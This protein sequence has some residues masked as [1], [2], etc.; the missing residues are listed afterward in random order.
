MKKLENLLRANIVLTQKEAQRLRR[1]GISKASTGVIGALSFLGSSTGQSFHQLKISFLLRFHRGAY[2]DLGPTEVQ[3]AIEREFSGKYVPFHGSEFSHS[4]Q[5]FYVEAIINDAPIRN[6]EGFLR[7]KARGFAK[8]LVVTH[9]LKIC[10][11]D[12]L[13]P[14]DIG[15]GAI[16]M[17]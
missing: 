8:N 17:R 6:V 9:L 1:A 10:E 11:D 3:S 16:S 12:A 15:P 7:S 5:R 13:T 2:Y 14:E 4:E